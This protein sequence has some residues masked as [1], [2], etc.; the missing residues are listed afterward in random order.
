[1]AENG[2]LTVEGFRKYIISD[3]NDVYVPSHT[4]V[5]QVM[6]CDVM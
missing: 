2:I 5:Y 4:T 6:W 3:D 1:M